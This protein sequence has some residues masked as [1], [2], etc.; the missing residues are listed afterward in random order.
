[1][2][3]EKSNDV[4]FLAEHLRG[5][6]DS[7]LF[8][9]LADAYLKMD[10]VREAIQL[11][12]SGIK[13]HPYY[14]TGHLVLGKSYLANKMYDQAEK[15]F[16]RVLLFDPKH[17]AAHKLYGDLMQEIGW[18]NTCEMSYKKILQIDPL[19]EVARSR[20]GEYILEAGEEQD[21]TEYLASRP[22]QADIDVES[23]SPI[24]KSSQEEDLLFQDKEPE[25]E[26]TPKPV[27]SQQPEVDESK[28]E[29][30]SSILDDIFKDEVVQEPEAE[31]SKPDAPVGNDDLVDE[32]QKNP[33]SYFTETETSS[34]EETEQT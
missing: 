9:R 18:E 31:S 7:I 4:E 25:L 24:S 14:V 22:A 2:F 23:M 3:S 32:I 34:E 29:K 33:E 27:E 16:K 17:L 12:E 6:P 1:M 8:A 30:F 10:R 21:D 11:C 13:K 26:T 28:E 19:D 20:V 15:E 5:N